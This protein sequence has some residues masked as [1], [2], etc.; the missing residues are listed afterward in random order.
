MGGLYTP[1]G[2]LTQ[3]SKPDLSPTH[4]SS[5]GEMDAQKGQERSESGRDSTN[6]DQWS[7]GSSLRDCQAPGPGFCGESSFS[8]RRPPVLKEGASQPDAGQWSLG[9]R[10]GVGL[11]SPQTQAGSVPL[12]AGCRNPSTLWGLLTDRALPSSVPSFGSPPLPLPLP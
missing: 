10:V 11:S 3:L 1:L 8:L 12:L 2:S 9:V 6:P 5:V 4:Q 7:P